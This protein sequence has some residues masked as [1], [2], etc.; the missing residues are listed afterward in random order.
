MLL[1]PNFLATDDQP[2]RLFVAGSVAD[3]AVSPTAVPRRVALGVALFTPDTVTG[4]TSRRIGEL[5]PE[6]R[7]REI[8]KSAQF[9]RHE[10]VR[11]VHK[12]DGLRRRLKIL[13]KRKQLSGFYR[14]SDK[15]GERHGDPEACARSIASRLE[16][17]GN[18]A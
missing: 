11:C 4:N 9:R 14:F 10:T 1:S 6:T 15:I 8:E 7:H 13:Q 16:I 12:A 18:E 3:H 17:A 2:R 5:R